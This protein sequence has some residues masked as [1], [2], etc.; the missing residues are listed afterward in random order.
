MTFEELKNEFARMS[1]EEKQRF[2]EE[3]GLG[4]CKDMMADTTFMQRMFPRCMEMMQNM[5]ADIRRHMEQM[6]REAGRTR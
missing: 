3:V 5:P 6:M 4:L 1:R 2:M